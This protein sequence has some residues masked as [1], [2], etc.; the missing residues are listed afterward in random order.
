M[1]VGLICLGV[2]VAI[3][4]SGLL[5]L[6]AQRRVPIDQQTDSART[7]V[8]QIAGVL[9]LLLSLVLGNLIGTSFAFNTTQKTE[10][11][12]LSAYVLQLDDA[13]SRLGPDAKTARETL[14]QTMQNALD[15]FWGSE[16]P[17]PALLAV[18][19]PL[20]TSRTIRAFLDSVEPTTETQKQTLAS[21]NASFAQLVH[22]RLLISL[23]VA[24]HP[25]RPGLVV[26][27]TLW[28]VALFFAFGVLA[29]RN[30]LIISAMGLGAVCIA[31][32]IFVVLELGLPY[33][34]LFRVTPAAL[35]EAVDN[36]GQ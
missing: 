28:A 11:D 29:K 1:R 2:F 7:V 30:W 15:A 26:V 12:S 20:K 3:I 16:D 32:A 34:G 10:L 13:L 9:S 35:E 4:A 19:I 33:S 17:D 22:W 23:Q 14:K 36:L 5:G 27:L 6:Q 24:G 8:A 31:V 25:V 18:S 21:A